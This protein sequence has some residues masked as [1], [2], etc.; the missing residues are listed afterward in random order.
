MTCPLCGDAL[1][2]SRPGDF[3]RI[4]A[5]IDA[6]AA[7]NDLTWVGCLDCA[8]GSVSPFEIWFSFEEECRL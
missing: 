7:I 5:G 6:E 1:V 3:E 2:Y 8:I 4:L